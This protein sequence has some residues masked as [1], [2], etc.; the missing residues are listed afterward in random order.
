[1]AATS[2]SNS[3][4]DISWTPI[5]Y[6]SNTGGYRVYYSTTPGRPYT[7]FDMTADKNGSFLTVIGLNPGTP[8]YFVVQ[9]RTDP[10]A[11]NQNT[12]DS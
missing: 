3:S 4:L 11:M 8:Y 6:T 1:M 5:I 10:P 2:A 9:T 12:V 7:Y